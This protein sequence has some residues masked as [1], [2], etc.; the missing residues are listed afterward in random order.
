MAND[1]GQRLKSALAETP[2]KAVDVAHA[3]GVTAAAVSQWLSG[4]TVPRLDKIKKI[5]EFLNVPLSNLVA[6][7]GKI[8]SDVMQLRP[9]QLKGE[10]KR[11][12]PVY[13]AAEGG[14]G[15]MLIQQSAIEYTYRSETSRG[16]TC[17]AVHVVGD[18][19]EPAFAQGDQVVVDPRRVPAAGDD[20]IFAAD[21]PGG[22]YRA[23]I[24][25]LLRTTADRWLVRQYNPP[26]DFA[27]QK[28]E[29]PKVFKIIEK[30]F[31]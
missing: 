11:D 16:L 28:S 18:S 6:P 3:V 24:K 25:R 20:C 7:Q 17:F 21:L 22:E 5:A 9:E 10:Y 13:A 27:L 2:Y 23:V 8:I 4:T 26:K 31:R 14:S 12:L 30:R 15:S 1:F 29:W 19:M